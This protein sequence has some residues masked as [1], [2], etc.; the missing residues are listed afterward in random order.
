M[1]KLA[2]ALILLAAPVRAETLHY[3]AY[4][5]GVPAAEVT[6]RL[7]TDTAGYR[8]ELALR[9]RGVADLLVHARVRSMANGT[10]APDGDHRDT[11]PEHY[12][13]RGRTAGRD[14]TTVIDYT[15]DA[16]IVR[17]LLPADDDPREPIPP[18]L[19]ARTEDGNSAIAGLLHVA[20]RTGRCDAT[21]RTFDG[22]RLSE[23]VLRTA[24]AEDVLPSGRSVFAGPAL[25]CDFEGRLL[26]GFKLDEDRAR[27]ARPVHGSV[28]LA[29]IGGVLTPVRMTFETRAF[30]TATAYLIAPETPRGAP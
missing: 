14:R 2:V 6:V 22:R 24:G 23:T 4:A 19:Q 18:E 3:L 1:Q 17:L 12:E 26:A 29:R 28:W 20:E 15:P 25:R 10:W 8:I 13:S 7:D 27:A 5:A 30:G 21:A 9:T 16:P 11:L